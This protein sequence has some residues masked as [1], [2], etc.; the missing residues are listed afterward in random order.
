MDIVGRLRTM[1]EAV[2][3]PEGKPLPRSWGDSVRKNAEFTPDMM[4]LTNKS[5]LLLFNPD[6]KLNFKDN[7][8]VAFTNSTFVVYQ[9]EDKLLLLPRHQKNGDPPVW[10]KAPMAYPASV[11][12]ELVWVTTTSILELDRHYQNGVECERT[13]SWMAI[14]FK[15][16]NTNNIYLLSA[17]ASIYIARRKFWHRRLDGGYTTKELPALPSGIRVVPNHVVDPRYEHTKRR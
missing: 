4:K 11:K 1:T 8:I 7:G 13:T 6:P 15:S 9:A 12:G 5:S 17:K 16:E 2:L 3:Y 14:P 10:G